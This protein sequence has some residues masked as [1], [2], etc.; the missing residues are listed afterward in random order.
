MLKATNGDFSGSSF[1]GD[2][3]TGVRVSY[4]D[5]NGAHSID[6]AP[7]VPVNYDSATSFAMIYQPLYKQ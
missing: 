6:L 5:A 2:A 1:D 3:Q 4:V 7:D